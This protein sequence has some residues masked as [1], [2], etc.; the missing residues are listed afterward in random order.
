MPIRETLN[1]SPATLADILSNGKRYCVP[2][3]QRD[4]AW[5]E[6]EWSELWADIREL[7][8]PAADAANH[9]LGALVLQPTGQPSVMNI[10]DGQQRLVTL[11][12]LALAVIA[13]IERLARDGVEPDENKERTRLLRER[14]VSTKDAASLMHRSRLTLNVSDNP[15]YQTYLVQCVMPPRPRA[16]KG[17][18]KLLYEAFAYFDKAVAEHLGEHATGEALARFIEG[19]VASRLRF[20]EIEV[21]DDETAFSVFETLNARGVALGTADLLKNFVFSMAAAGGQ[22]DLEQARMLWE[23]I[24]VPVPMQSLSSLLFHKL[25]STVPDLREKRVFSE[26]KRLVPARQTVFDFLRDL[27]DAA[28]VYAA[29]D[30]PHDELWLEMD[31]ARRSVRVLSILGAH[32]YRPIILAA[33]P[34]L[35]QR[36][37]RFARLLHNLVMIAVRATVSRVNTGDVQRASQAAAIRIAAGELKSPQAIARSLSAIVPSDDEFRSAFAVLAI[38]PKGPR[39][40]WL[41]YLL[42]ELEGASGGQVIDFDVADVTIEHVLPENPGAEWETFGHE[43]RRR[44]TVRL[45]NLTPLEPQLNKLLGAADFASKRE[46]YQ[47]SKFHLTRAIA[48]SEWTPSALRARQATMAD[49]AVGIWKVEGDDAE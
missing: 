7:G 22:S 49:L 46:T 12:I 35:M 15:F 8:A 25:A 2:M 11:S 40:R 6:T 38:N 3:F 44:D 20:I 16:L 30:D 37:K 45:G 47:Q 13:R 26:V 14:L 27:K 1:A 5:G 41:R 19:T 32:Q 18:E 17:S 4:Y 21:E 28:E 10:I 34:A 9:Y 39:K 24:L 31:D 29:L 48:A 42:A 33:Y 23:Q 36:P 43:D